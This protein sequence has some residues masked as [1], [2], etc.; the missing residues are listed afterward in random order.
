MFGS[1]RVFSKKS[2]RQPLG[3]SLVAVLAVTNLG[4]S[5]AD[6]Q[7]A[8]KQQTTK[9]QATTQPSTAQG[10]T[11]LESTLPGTTI[12]DVV[13]SAQDDALPPPPDPTSAGTTLGAKTVDT[14]AL[15]KLSDIVAVTPG[16]FMPQT[17]ITPSHVTVFMRGFGEL[18]QQGRPSIPIYIDDV[19]IPRTQGANFNFIDLDT[20]DI[21][22]GP[23]GFT[24]GH[25]AEAGTISVHTKEPTDTFTGTLLT[26]YGSYNE[27]KTGAALSGPILPGLLYGSLAFQHRQRDGYTDNVSNGREGNNIDITDLRGKLRFTPNEKLEI[28]TK[29]DSTLDNSDATLWSDRSRSTDPN[30]AYSNVDPWNKYRQFG[31]SNVVSYALT[32]ELKLKSI[33]AYR[34]YRSDTVFDNTGDPYARGIGVLSY[35]DRSVTQ[36]TRLSGQYDRFNFV[37]GNWLS[38][39]NWLRQGG[40]NGSTTL[41]PDPNAS[42]YYPVYNLLKT[43]ERELAFFGQGTLK[44]TDALSLTLGGRWNYNSA[45]QTVEN[46]SLGGSAGFRTSDWLLDQALLYSTANQPIGSVPAGTSLNWIA[47]AKDSWQMFTPKASI[48][49]QWR[50]EFS[51]YA[52]FSKGQ[53]TGGFDFGGLTPFASSRLQSS[54]PYGPEVVKN[55]E[56]GFRASLLNNKVTLNGAVFYD[57]I[58]DVQ[59]TTTD[60]VSLISRRFNAGSGHSKGVELESSILDILPGLDVNL[61]GGYLD[62]QLDDFAGIAKTVTYANGLVLNSTPFDGA[63]LPNAPTWQGFLGLTYT[64]PVDLPGTYRVGG[65]V[66]YKSA[67]FNDALNNS[68]NQI[69]DQTLINGFLSY[70]TADTHWTFRIDLRNALDER[71]PQWANYVVQPGTGTLLYRGTYYNEPRT[72]FTSLKY[73]F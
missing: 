60:P 27:V 16:V 58:D 22:R 41:A 19:Y 4:L 48:E 8:T 38:K 37:V 59:L 42:V 46:Y 3:Y 1:H 9:Q 45:H 33:T 32:D 65:N 5:R 52:T 2:I 47:N 53:K 49:Y 10:S 56:L 11:T 28:I 66:Q 57:A 36:E 15:G 68:V 17:G 70:T 31:A 24:S 23:Q 30:I 43:D 55:Y 21:S 62:A 44:V 54:L 26:G 67:T 14:L 63:R 13:V 29:L 20:I 39:E 25:S 7:E 69:P 73:S 50:P 51:T 71:Y 61:S 6:A 18:H 64:V 12:Q 34:G 40:N 35:D 72:I